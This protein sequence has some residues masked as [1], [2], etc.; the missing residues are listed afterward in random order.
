MR[1]HLLS[2]SNQN[3]WKHS[4]ENDWL[5]HLIDQNFDKESTQMFWRKFTNKNLIAQ[6][7]NAD[8]YPAR[9]KT[10]GSQRRSTSS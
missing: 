9:P 1:L 8:I 4:I 2:K 7:A 6:L 5:K 3:T 10:N